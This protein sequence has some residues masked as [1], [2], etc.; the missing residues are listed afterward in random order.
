MP[1]TWE[2]KVRR[3]IVFIAV[4]GKSLTTESPAVNGP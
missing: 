4:R 3:D 1:A 2:V